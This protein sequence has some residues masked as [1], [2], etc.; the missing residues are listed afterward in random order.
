MIYND[1]IIPLDTFQCDMDCP[2]CPNIIREYKKDLISIHAFM[3]PLPTECI[4]LGGN[5]ETAMLDMKSLEIIVTL[6]DRRWKA[7]VKRLFTSGYIFHPY[8][9]DKWALFKNHGWQFEVSVTSMDWK[10]NVALLLGGHQDCE[11]EYKVLPFNYFDSD[12]FAESDIR[13][14]YI[15]LNENEA[16]MPQEIMQIAE[17]YPN[18]RVIT[19]EILDNTAG[20]GHEWVSRYALP[21]SKRKDIQKSLNEHFKR[22]KPDKNMNVWE[23]RTS[24]GST[25]VRFLSR[26]RETPPYAEWRR[27]KFY[28]HFD[29]TQHNASAETETADTEEQKNTF[30]WTETADVETAGTEAT[31]IET[32]ET[33]SSGNMDKAGGREENHD[34]TVEKLAALLN[35]L[36]DAGYG[37]MKIFCE[38]EALYEEYISIN[39][40]TRKMVFTGL[41]YGN[42]SS[43]KIMEFC[44][45]AENA[46][47]MISEAKYRLLY[48]LEK[49]EPKE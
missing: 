42:F 14:N 5:G 20:K 21:E 31:G 45:E 46:C 7:P 18:I 32:A 1:V 4:T 24:H 34:L 9:R 8:N 16:S 23:L 15:L 11:E 13:L 35:K 49:D 10:K 47:N 29:D 39:Y 12:T 40:L 27:D 22:I 43:R 26:N 48:E 19:L 44:R 6:I 25:A 33:E 37:D 38:K 2:Y 41:M 30:T 17:A 3:T 36:K 28:F